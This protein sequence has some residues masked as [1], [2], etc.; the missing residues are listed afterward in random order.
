M[1]LTDIRSQN[2]FTL[3]RQALRRRTEFCPL[4]DSDK[5]KTA[6]ELHASVAKTNDTDQQYNFCFLSH[7]LM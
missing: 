7:K 3:G 5:A 1:V 4:S 2:A 6:I